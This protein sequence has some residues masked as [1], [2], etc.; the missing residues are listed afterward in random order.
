MPAAIFGLKTWETWLGPVLCSLEPFC[1]LSSPMSTFP[2]IIN[3]KV[4]TFLAFHGK[5][6]S[7]QTS[8]T[9]TF[10]TIDL[11]CHPFLQFSQLVYHNFT[12]KWTGKSPFLAIEKKKGASS[13]PP[14]S[15]PPS[16][17]VAR[18]CRPRRCAAARREWC[19]GTDEPPAHQLHLSC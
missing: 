9:V 14:P 15:A 16:P 19:P 2:L 5:C 12:W 17:Q 7:G 10:L 11:N 6:G 4:S 13:A 8:F 18:H 1:R 3:L